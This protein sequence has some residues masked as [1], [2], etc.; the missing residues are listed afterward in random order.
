MPGIQRSGPLG[1]E[2]VNSDCASGFVGEAGDELLGARALTSPGVTF[3]FAREPSKYQFRTC[4]G[5]E[6]KNNLN[7]FAMA[8]RGDPSVLVESTGLFGLS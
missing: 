3:A 7:K 6:Q 5:V 4:M 8:A 2:F 1:N